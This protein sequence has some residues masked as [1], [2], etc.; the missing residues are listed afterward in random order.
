MHAV[1]GFL[2]ESGSS[3]AE[4]LLLCVVCYQELLIVSTIDIT[5][6]KKTTNKN[7]DDFLIESTA[8]TYRALFQTQLC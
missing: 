3:R 2:Y 4:C 1:G 8:Q 5:R 6:T 7:S